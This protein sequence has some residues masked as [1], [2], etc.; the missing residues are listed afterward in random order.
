MT[1]I[2]PKV[3]V[4]CSWYNRPDYI[5]DTVDSLL[6]QDFDSFEVIIINDGSSDPRVREIFD[7]Y[8][9]PRLRIVHQENTGF[10]AAIRKAIELTSGEYIAV[11]GAGD[12][13]RPGRLRVQ[14]AFLDTH[15]DYV[16]VG[17][18]IEN[19]YAGG[20]LDGK[21]MELSKKPGPIQSE[22]FYGNVPNPL[23]H[24][25]VTYRRSIYNNVGGYRPFFSTAQDRDLWLRMIDYGRFAVADGTHY[26]RR[27]FYADGIAGSQKKTIGQIRLSHFARE[28]YFLRQKFGLDLV[29]VFGVQAGLFSRASKIDADMLARSALHY[30]LEN[31][32]EDA[33]FLLH[34]SL[35]DRWTTKN[36]ALSLLMAAQ[37]IPAF[38]RVAKLLLARVPATGR[39]SE[40]IISE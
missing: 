31:Q 21:R 16:G 6:A 29:D 28:N 20:P 22:R 17:C 9:D 5:S 27:I 25:E 1:K 8:D 2:P 35:K 36:L 13:S 10:V 7:R 18:S 40:G 11:Q 30:L 3:S 37:E 19:V 24:G 15:S 4:V 33:R 23:S 39:K 38:G 12:V 32:K 34:L 26:E 14:A